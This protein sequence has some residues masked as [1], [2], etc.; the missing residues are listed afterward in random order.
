MSE[1]LTAMIDRLKD[2]EDEIE[3]AFEARRTQFYTEVKDGKARFDKAA[4][5]RQRQL[6]TRISTYLA[7]SSLPTLLTV[8]LVYGLAVPLAFL[9]AALWLYQLGC[10]TVWR[11]PR[12]KR[13]DYVVID[14]HRLAYLNGIEK[15]NCVYCGYAN[16]VIAYAREIASRT[17]QYWCPIKHALR[18]KGAHERYQDFVEYGDAKGFKRSSE[19]FRERLRQEESPTSLTP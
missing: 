2:L 11:I 19:V 12:V 7:Q 15:L 18:T 17:E 13:S 14:R 5:E 4:L 1:N 3:R 8:P 9:D 6:K 16:G 10:F